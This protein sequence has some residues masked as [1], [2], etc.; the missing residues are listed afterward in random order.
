[1][2]IL[3]TNHCVFLM[4]GLSKTS[5]GL[6][7][8]SQNT[9][10]KYLSLGQPIYVCKITIAELYYGAFNSDPTR[11]TSNLNRLEVFKHSLNI[12]PLE[13][14]ILKLFAQKRVVLTKSG[15]RPPDFDL[16]IGCTAIFHDAVLATNDG[17]FQKHLPEVKVE[18]WSV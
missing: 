6:T 10:N 1:M 9:V 2:Y 17:F 14:G 15:N 16:L 5:K 11:V 3:D 18:D 4:N 7:A 12:L 13:E 8:Q